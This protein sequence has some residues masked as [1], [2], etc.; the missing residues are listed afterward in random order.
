MND[1][2]VDPH[3]WLNHLRTP[4]WTAEECSHTIREH[5]NT[6]VDLLELVSFQYPITIRDNRVLFD[7]GGLKLDDSFWET[8]SNNVQSSELFSVPMYGFSTRLTN[9]RKYPTETMAFRTSEDR[10]FDQFQD[11][12]L[13]TFEPV[14]VTAK[15]HDELWYYIQSTTYTGWVKQSDI[16]LCSREEF[17]TIYK[18]KDICIV[19]NSSVATQAQPYDSQISCIPVE[20]GAVLPLSKRADESIGNQ[21]HHGNLRVLLPL[22]DANGKFYT[23][24]AFIRK[25]SGVHTGYLPFTRK[26]IVQMA[27]SLLGERYGWGGRFGHHDCSSFVMDI[28]RTA[29]V[30]L[31]RDA[32]DQEHALPNHIKI[33][34]HATREQR[35]ELLCQLSAGDLLFM[36]GHVMMYLGLLNGEH[37]MI[38]DF[39]GHYENGNRIPINQIMVTPVTIYAGEAKT[40]L[41]SL[42]GVLNLFVRCD[43]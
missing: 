19:A 41:E 21:S 16:A 28:Y 29:G 22:S 43:K 39:S 27:F 4:E 33:S 3:Y 31:P 2:L 9:V 11:T 7:S 20:F 23:K 40:Y 37:Y 35:H 15:S 24:E 6:V 18:T 32:G 26:T 5:N 13:H 30:Q 36:P 25:S 34:D 17:H 12:T 1:L 14:V 10:E 8:T 38:H 42:T